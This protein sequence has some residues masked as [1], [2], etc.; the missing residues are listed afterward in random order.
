VYIT[1]ILYNPFIQTDRRMNDNER[2][3]HHLYKNNPKLVNE[4]VNKEEIKIEDVKL[5]FINEDH[6]R[7]FKNIQEKILLYE[8]FENDF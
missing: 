6:E 3:Y 4:W 1:A 7:I 2:F 8:I 5:P